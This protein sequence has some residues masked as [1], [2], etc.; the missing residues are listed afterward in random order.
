ME[1]GNGLVCYDNAFYDL[2]S[3]KIRFVI[4][5]NFIIKSIFQN[6]LIELEFVV[7]SRD[8]IIKVQEERVVDLFDINEFDKMTNIL[9][10]TTIVRYFL[11]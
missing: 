9:I 6:G 5:N 7:D 8:Y 10:D 3:L 1:M 2:E 11:S 4:S